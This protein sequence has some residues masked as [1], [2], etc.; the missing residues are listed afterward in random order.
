LIG[1]S[2]RT[3]LYGLMLG[4][5]LLAGCAMPRIPGMPG[6]APPVPGGAAPPAGAA[7][8]P[9]SAQELRTL[10]ER[11]VVDLL[12]QGQEEQAVAELQRALR[13][14]PNHRLAN[15]LMRQIRE[16]PQTLY[17]RE[18]F[19]YRVQSGESLSLVAQ[20][21][22]GEIYQFYGLARYNGI[23]VPRQVV[24]GQQIKVPGKAP[25]PGATT[26]A[27]A[28]PPAV[29][30]AVPPAA[31]AAPAQP[32]V[33]QPPAAQPPAAQPVQ[34]DPAAAAERAER[35]RTDAIA[36]HTRTA[37]A[38]FA[39]QDLD[40]AIAAWDRV[41]ELDPNNGTAKLE[42]QRAVDLK[43]RLKKV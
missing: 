17:G 6:G 43:E 34:P 29:P 4:V 5:G 32:P 9:M 8:P 15:S 22:L 3:A 2:R 37:R 39:K 41:L 30:P 24:G 42:R 36:R 18:S 1:S 38:A 33:A 26:A 12:E 23:K 11:T 40:G 31:P 7:Q 35:A 13:Q 16:D 21:F 27:P 10:V 20:R 19:D 25:P 28:A 14:D